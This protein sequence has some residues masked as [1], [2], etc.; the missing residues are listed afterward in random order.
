M[1]RMPPPLRR[2]PR[3]TALRKERILWARAAQKAL[4]KAL[5]KNQRF[6]RLQWFQP[7]PACSP[8]RIKKECRLR[9]NNRFAAGIPNALGCVVRWRRGCSYCR[10]WGS[11]T[12]SK[13][14][15]A[16]KR[17]RLLLSKAKAIR[18]TFS[19]TLF[20]IWK[21]KSSSVFHPIHF[22]S[23]VKHFLE[24]L[25]ILEYSRVVVFPFESGE[26]SPVRNPNVRSVVLSSRI[27][28][29]F[30]RI[31]AVNAVLRIVHSLHDVR[32]Y[33]PVSPL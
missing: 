4:L 25:F 26:N 19:Q 15:S 32:H 6:R 11:T 5:T 21:R 13:P 8:A 2:N 29:G 28:G 30:A 24:V 22:V 18:R 17:S 12:P 31:R 14:W 10:K 7:K 16:I 33:S 27:P 20:C 9:R 3:T 23:V 1:R